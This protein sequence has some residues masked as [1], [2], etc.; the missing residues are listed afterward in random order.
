MGKSLLLYWNNIITRL[1]HEVKLEF[2]KCLSSELELPSRSLHGHMVH[3]EAFSLISQK[4][5]NSLH[6]MQIVQLKDQSLHTC[7]DL[8]PL[9]RR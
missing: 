9:I 2:H 7:I 4:K 3:V 8:S 5:K 6:T 1:V